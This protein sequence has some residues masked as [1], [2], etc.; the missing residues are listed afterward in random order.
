MERLNVLIT[1]ATGLFGSWMTQA[2]ADRGDR[3]V[4]LVR[5][6]VPHS[7]F[8]H[9]NLNSR[10]TTVRGCIEDY[11]LIERALCEYEIDTVIHLAAQTIVGIANEN[12]LSTFE[13]NIKGTWQILEACRR[14]PKV[15]RIVV[16][17]S[18]KAYGQQ[19][20]LPYK[21]H[22]PLQGSYPYDV[23]KSCADL[24]CQSYAKSYGLPVS[25]IRCANL[26]G[27]GDLNFNRLIPGTIAS[28]IQGERPII[29]S[30]VK[31]VR[32]YLHVDD[33][34]LGVLTIL[35]QF[36]S[37]HLG[38]SVFN[39]GLDLRINVLQLTKR[40]LKIMNNSTLTPKILNNATNEITRQYLSSEKAKKQ[41]GWRPQLSLEKGLKKTISWY[42]AFLKE[43]S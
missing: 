40:I 34:V 22:H 5:D 37:K 8:Y 35:D 14:R 16:S 29:R 27:G 17:T 41:L 12:P 28:I 9:L 4:A 13:A 10:V 36:E 18:D 39:L 6:N 32:G 31:L 30:N 20:K 3:V 7:N 11:D 19:A 24:I 21:E 23:S 1:G 38:G 25:I 26:F 15:K 2:L 43:K 42:E 33:A